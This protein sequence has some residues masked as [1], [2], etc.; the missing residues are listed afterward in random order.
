MVH[1]RYRGGTTHAGARSVSP[2]R[3]QEDGAT[4]FVHVDRTSRLIQDRGR[5]IRQGRP[6]VSGAEYPVEGPH[7]VWVLVR[8]AQQNL[9]CRARSLDGGGVGYI[10]GQID[11]GA[12][13]VL[14][15][16]DGAVAKY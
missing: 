2:C 9:P 3:S 8:L 10:R 14:V 7:D 15:L 1:G 6:L 13:G 11:L 12:H 5:E 16:L 4:C